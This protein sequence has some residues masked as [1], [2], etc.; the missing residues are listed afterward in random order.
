M[1]FRSI[2]LVGLWLSD[3][4]VFG[5]KTLYGRVTSTLSLSV[6]SFTPD[7]DADEILTAALTPFV[8]TKTRTAASDFHPYREWI[9]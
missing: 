8:H 4:S 6:E 7:P 3:L 9:D 1:L 2:S 5:L